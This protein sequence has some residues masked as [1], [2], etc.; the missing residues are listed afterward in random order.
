MKNMTPANIFSY[1]LEKC[2]NFLI[3]K[4]MFICIIK[5]QTLLKIAKLC[6]KSIISANPNPNY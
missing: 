3:S 5:H 2:Y 1:K 4:V 6:L